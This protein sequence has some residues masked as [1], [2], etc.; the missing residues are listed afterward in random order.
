MDPYLGGLPGWQVTLQPVLAALA[1]IP[2]SL[3]ML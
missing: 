2:V 3:A 1:V